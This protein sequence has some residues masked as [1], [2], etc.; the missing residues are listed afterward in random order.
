MVSSLTT[1]R[2]P[3]RWSARTQLRRAG[4]AGASDGAVSYFSIGTLIELPHSVQEPS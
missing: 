2:S 4:M 3:P 1:L